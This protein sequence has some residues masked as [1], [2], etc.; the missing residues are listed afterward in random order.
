MP[1]R[2]GERSFTEPH[3]PVWDTRKSLFI[4]DIAN[5]LGEGGVHK[6]SAADVTDFKAPSARAG[7]AKGPGSVIQYGAQLFFR[8]QE[9]HR[10]PGH[11][12]TD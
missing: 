3:G 10:G 5:G 12:N 8:K 6:V 2:S 7:S 4:V 1:T 11:G 9:D